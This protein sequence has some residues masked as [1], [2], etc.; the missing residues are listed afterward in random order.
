ML[1]V[2]V[3]PADLKKI[4][5]GM[6]GI[7]PHRLLRVCKSYTW[8]FTRVTRDLGQY[9]IRD[10][11]VGVER[12][13]ALRSSNRFIRTIFHLG[14]QAEDGISIRVRV[15]QQNGLTSEHFSA[16]ERL[17]LAIELPAISVRKHESQHNIGVRVS[18]IEC[19][20]FLE[21]LA[22]AGE[23]IRGHDLKFLETAQQIVISFQVIG[24]LANDY[25]A[26]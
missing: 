14:H 5:F 13:R 9:G 3:C 21:H 8:W 10:R 16:I 15:V 26:L 22:A 6:V 12:D 7:E 1:H 2:N 18:G 11:V 17:R 20:R 4:K 23:L 19:D 25:S 24:S